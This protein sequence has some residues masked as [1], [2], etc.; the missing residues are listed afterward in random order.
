MS[1]RYPVVDRLELEPRG[2]G[3]R[4]FQMLKLACCDCGLVH[5][6]AF[7][8]E[9]N[10]NLGIALRRNNRATAAKRRAARPNRNMLKGEN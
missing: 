4:E 7:A 2:Q 5:D 8:I 6:M 3:K 10:G 9:K 1:K